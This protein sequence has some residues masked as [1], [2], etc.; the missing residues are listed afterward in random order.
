M[1]CQRLS[2]Q[3]LTAL[4]DELDDL[5]RHLNHRRER[6]SDWLSRFEPANRHAADTICRRIRHFRSDFGYPSAE[7]DSWAEYEDPIAI[8]HNFMIVA[9]TRWSAPFESIKTKSWFARCVE[10]QQVVPGQADAAD[11][12]FGFW[13]AVWSM[14]IVSVQPIRQVLGAVI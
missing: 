4:L 14:P 12:W 3:G 1:G 5:E 8:W 2:G 11:G 10:P 13:T 7:F 6:L 9:V